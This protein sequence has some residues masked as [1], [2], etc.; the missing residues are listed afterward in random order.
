ML[1][2]KKKNREPPSEMGRVGMSVFGVALFSM[3]PGSFIVC[4]MATYLFYLHHA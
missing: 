1:K 3:L 2:K 4:Y